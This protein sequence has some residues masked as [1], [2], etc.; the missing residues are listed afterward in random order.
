MG[1]P[2]RSAL[3]AAS[4]SALRFVRIAGFHRTG[5]PVLTLSVQLRSHVCSESRGAANHGANA[6]SPQRRLCHVR[7]TSGWRLHSPAV[8]TFAS[9]PMQ[10]VTRTC[11]QQSFHRKL[12]T[13]MLQPFV[14]NCMDCAPKIKDCAY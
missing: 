1:S 3:L 9:V 7:A 13:Y 12:S 2:A 14:G 5:Q 6:V 11:A 4:S 8:R 10:S